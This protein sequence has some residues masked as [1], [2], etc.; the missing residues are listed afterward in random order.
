MNDK[1]FAVQKEKKKAK[2]NFN[3]RIEDET[4]KFY[5]RGSRVQSGFSSVQDWQSAP[6]SFPECEDLVPH[7][8][9]FSSSYQ[10]RWPAK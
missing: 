6:G 3:K 8:S 7:S 2:N 5:P 9:C 10:D 4:A 1:L